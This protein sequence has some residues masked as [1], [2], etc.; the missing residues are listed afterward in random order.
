MNDKIFEARP[1]LCVVL[2]PDP[3]RYTVHAVSNDYV[4]LT[5]IERSV[6]TGKEFFSFLPPAPGDPHALA[7][8]NLRASL[9]YVIDNKVP[10]EMTLQRYD[11]PDD[12]GSFAERY[13]KTC[14]V[15]VCDD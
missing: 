12:K 3:P 9:Q 10:H 11:V 15:P 6:I 2:L 5:G 4:Q 13:W 8:Q 1:G 14:N 7:E